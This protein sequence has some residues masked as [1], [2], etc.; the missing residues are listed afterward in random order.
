[1]AVNIRLRG[2]FPTF[3][4]SKNKIELIVCLEMFSLLPLFLR[5][6]V[7]NMHSSFL[8]FSQKIVYGQVL[9][10][11]WW[12]D[13]FHKKRNKIQFS[14]LRLRTNNRM[15]LGIHVGIHDVRSNYINKRR[16]DFFFFFVSAEHRN[17][18][19]KL[20]VEQYWEDHFKALPIA[21]RTELTSHLIQH[22]FCW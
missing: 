21:R 13:R 11:N 8:F 20:L 2:K 6:L 4:P 19:L 17:F 15:V 22:H 7:D 5:F 14:I 12:H 16:V 3:L 10:I 1:M 9:V 18:K